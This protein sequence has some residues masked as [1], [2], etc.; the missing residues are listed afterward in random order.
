MSKIDDLTNTIK[1]LNA[2]IYQYQQQLVKEGDVCGVFL[3]TKKNE[4][5]GEKIYQLKKEVDKIEK[6]IQITDQ[7]PTILLESVD[8]Y[9]SSNGY[10]IV[11]LHD[12]KTI[13]GEVGCNHYENN[14]I[15]YVIDDE[16]QNNGYGFQAVVAMF[17]YLTANNVEDAK[18]VIKKKN[19]PSIKLAEKLTTIFP[20][21]NRY[22][23]GELIIYHFNLSKKIDKNSTNSVKFK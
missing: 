3:P 2:L 17:H 21:F 23:T 11:C 18:I 13:I 16:Y 9:Q 19:A 14:N 4:L 10:Y 20:N 8:L 5:L 12:T 7:S 15:H 6:T 1:R 22:E